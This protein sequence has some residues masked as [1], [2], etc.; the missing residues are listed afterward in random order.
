MKK[1][2]VIIV[3]IATTFISSVYAF[4]QQTS[5]EAAQK[6]AE[7]NL[8]LAVEAEKKASVNAAEVSAVV[9]QASQQAKLAMEERV[10]AQ[11]A[12]ENCM[13]RK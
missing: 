7:M 3:L 10:R 9:A 5:A 11:K 1:N 13:K 12:L 2:I 4:I 8:V 6:Q